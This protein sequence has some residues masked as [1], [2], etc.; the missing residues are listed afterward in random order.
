MYD[1]GGAAKQRECSCRGLP[2]VAH[3]H[4]HGAVHVHV[5]GAGLSCASCKGHHVHRYSVCGTLY[6]PVAC[7]S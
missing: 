1:T 3:V 2:P 6:A 7:C 5:R 4:V